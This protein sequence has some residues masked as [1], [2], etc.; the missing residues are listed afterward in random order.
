M[1]ATPKDAK[2]TYPDARGDSQAVFYWRR[3]M[4]HKNIAWSICA[5]SGIMG[6]EITRKEVMKMNVIEIGH[7]VL[8]INKKAKII[9]SVFNKKSKESPLSAVELAKQT[10]EI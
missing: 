1:R 8:D 4:E 9:Y 5:T 7:L 10:V 2:A 6:I 3:N